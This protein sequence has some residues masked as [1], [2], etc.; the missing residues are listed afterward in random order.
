MASYTYCSEVGVSCPFA[1]SALGYTP[2]LPVNATLLVIFS[3]MAG[4][5]LIQ[6]AVWKTWGFMTA[7]VLGSILEITGEIFWEIDLEYP[8]MESKRLECFFPTRIFSTN[9]LP[10][11]LQTSGSVL[12][13][14]AITTGRKPKTGT[15]LIIAGL[16]SQILAM[17]L[18]GIMC[19]EFGLRAHRDRYIIDP[20]TK[21]LRS[22]K[23]FKYFWVA[24]AYAYVMIFI[25]CIYGVVELSGGFE[26]SLA[27]NETMFISLEGLTILTAGYAMSLVHP[28]YVFEAKIKDDLK[29]LP[30]DEKNIL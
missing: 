25:Q 26:G 19:L 18:F 13:I 20:S 27:T 15:N 24:L 5:Q 1:A 7:I 16:F 2:S 29:N 22:S 3:L 4:V 6:G 17:V 10:F 21:R 8:A 11:L 9:L 23:R 30:E 14:N 28:G 12:A